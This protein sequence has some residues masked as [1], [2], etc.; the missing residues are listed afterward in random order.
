MN[1]NTRSP[2]Q[3]GFSLL[4]VVI[5][6]AIFAI[7][8]LALASLQGSLTRSS[9]DANLRSIAANMA[10]RT[11][12]DLQAFGRIDTDPANLIPAYNDI[13]DVPAATVTWGGIPFTRTIDVT[14]YF[15]TV[16]SDTFST[17]AP[18]G[19]VVSDFKLLSVNV[20]WG[21]AAEFQL[22]DT[23]SFTNAELGTGEITLTT[24]I[25]STTTQ[26]SSRT[27]T[28]DDDSDFNPF[29]N[30]TPGA[31]P[32]IVSLALTGSKFK[33]SLT[34]E[35]EVFRENL[36]TRFDVITYS[37]AGPQALFLRREEFIAVTCECELRAADSG[38]PGRRPAIW[39]GDEYIEPQ[40]VAKQYGVVQNN[41]Q[42]SP[43]CETCC[44]DHHDGGTGSEDPA[45][46]AAAILY[47]PFRPAT[48]YASGNHKHY[49]RQ[50][51]TPVL[52]VAGVGDGYVEACTL[53]RKD[54][55]FRVA[56]DFR[57][58]GLNTFPK[59]YL[60]TDAQVASYSNYV[61]GEISSFTNSAIALGDG[62]NLSA[63]I[64]TVTPPGR[65]AFGDTPA[66]DDLTLGYTYLPTP[67]NAEFQQLR[68]RGIYNG[69]LTKD[70]RTVI[71]CV[72]AASTLEDKMACKSGNVELDKTGSVNVL[73]LIPFFDVQTTFLSE[74]DED[75]IDQVI[76]VT[77][78]AVVTGNTHSRGMASKI[79]T[80][81]F[82]DAIARSHRGVLGFTATD[83]IDNRYS[84]YLMNAEIAVHIDANAPP[85]LGGKTITG[86]VTSSIGG[87]QASSVTMT[88]TEAACNFT[89]PNFSCYVP[90]GAVAPKMTITGYCKNNTNIKACTSDATTLPVT[91]GGSGCTAYG[92]YSLTPALEVNS[93][94][95]S[96]SKDT[97][98]DN[99]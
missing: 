15:Y 4:E 35:P 72:N 29:I 45:G 31:N 19:I 92:D 53:I 78:E 44:Q 82:A 52:A 10:E 75:P 67:L 94:I 43:F 22:D 90:P 65:T 27:A 87:V 20:A 25:S 81:S 77:N 17:T 54:G 37:Q 47:D 97:C 69:Y 96:L 48:E 98:V 26:G 46:D 57:M 24:M 34:P 36:E 83:P 38:H 9:V 95:V 1:R 28:Q 6:I 79:M 3:R 68:S 66:I 58:E 91:N 11:I 99:L 5:A 80:T 49:S 86:V 88:G 74:W 8:M 59:E 18:A 64:P 32:D 40:F 63:S 23:S 14:D 61:T 42:Q 85:P 89:A 73:E 55:F 76:A 12:E 39:A 51:N 30:Y 2:S 13:V 70:L 7:G 16:A 93:Y 41:I 56:Q 33:E 84:S 62:Y 71:A 21:D 60:V 50:R